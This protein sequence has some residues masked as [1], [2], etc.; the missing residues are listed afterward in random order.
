MTSFT[1]PGMRSL[2]SWVGSS[3]YSSTAANVY[4]WGWIQDDAST[5]DHYLVAKEGEIGLAA[6]YR[7]D[8]LHFLLKEDVGGAIKILIRMGLRSIGLRLES[9]G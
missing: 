4:G 1:S 9:D 8:H 6:V 3:S 7:Q 2:I 5:G